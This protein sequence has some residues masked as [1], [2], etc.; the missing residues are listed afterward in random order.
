VARYRN[1]NTGALV[2]VRDDK[3]LGP[4]W[5]PADKK[6]ATPKVPAKRAPAKSVASRESE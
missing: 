6:P 1:V 3:V 5:E 4:E 2:Q